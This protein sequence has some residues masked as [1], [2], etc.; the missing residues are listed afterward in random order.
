[1]DPPDYGLNFPT[2]SVSKAR[3]ETNK[4]ASMLIIYKNTD[5]KKHDII[6]YFWD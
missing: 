5:A 3:S 1:M 2:S 4:N 6:A